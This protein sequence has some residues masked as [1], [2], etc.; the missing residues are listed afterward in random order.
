MMLDEAG[1][2]SR[3]AVDIE[4]G[5]ACAFQEGKCPIFESTRPDDVVIFSYSA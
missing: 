1:G 3:A 5:A 4:G 2:G